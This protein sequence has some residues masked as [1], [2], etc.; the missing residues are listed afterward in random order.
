MGMSKHLNTLG[1]C[2]GA[3]ANIEPSG[4]RWVLITEC[5]DAP[6]AFEVFHDSPPSE[7]QRATA[8][9]LGQR[10]EFRANAPGNAGG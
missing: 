2:V 10:W 1:N 9:R 4:G 7:D 8:A 3:M 6:V 5:D